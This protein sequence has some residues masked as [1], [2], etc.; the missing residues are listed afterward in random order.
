MIES[1]RLTVFC[2][3]KTKNDMNEYVQ[4]AEDIVQ[5]TLDIQTE[6][7]L[8]VIQFFSKTNN[9]QSAEDKV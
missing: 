4:R 7:M 3:V 2:R 8:E 9:I 6:L 5:K 1:I